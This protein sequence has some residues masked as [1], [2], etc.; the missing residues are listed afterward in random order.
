MLE[1][2]N[3]SL[4]LGESVTQP[5]ATPESTAVSGTTG[6]VNGNNT[7]DIVDALLVAQYY[8]GFVLCD[9]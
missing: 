2:G 7:I 6:D 1:V 8:M 9:F 4:S 3:R 5:P